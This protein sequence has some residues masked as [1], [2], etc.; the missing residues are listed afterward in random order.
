MVSLR[1]WEPD[2]VGRD[3]EKSRLF[4]ASPVGLR[5]TSLVAYFDQG[6]RHRALPSSSS[7]APLRAALQV[8]FHVQHR[9]SSQDR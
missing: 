2:L 3:Q 4:L 8:A 5:G 9:V 6:R 1:G 7:L